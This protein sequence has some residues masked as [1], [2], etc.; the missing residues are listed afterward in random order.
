M[1]HLGSGDGPPTARVMIVGEMWGHSEQRDGRP[2]AGG[3]GEELNRMLHEAGLLRSECFVTNVVNAMP[4][5]GLI[6]SWIPKKKKEITSKMVSIRGKMCDPIIRQGIDAL[7]DEIKLVKPNLIIAAGNTALWALTGMEGILKWRG[8][9]LM[10]DGELQP[11]GH[12]RRKVIPIIH[13]A[14][15]FRDWSLRRIIIQDLRRAAKEVATEEYSNVPQWN[16]ITRPTLNEAVQKLDWLYWH[17]TRASSPVWVDF[18]LET[19]V[20]HIESAALSWSLTEAICLPFMTRE[21]RRGYWPTEEVEAAVVWRIYRVLRHANVRV[22]GQNLLYDSQYTYRHWHFVPRVAQDTMLAQHSLFCGLRKS[23]DFQASMYCDHYVYWKDDGKIA[24][25]S[26]PEDKRWRY[27]CEDCVRTREV[28]EVETALLKQ[29]GLEAV[30]AFQQKMFWPVLQCMQRGVKIDKKLRSDLAWKLQEEIDV[31]QAFFARV[32]GHPLNPRSSPQMAKL[33]YEDLKQKPI[34]KQRGKGVPSTLTWDDHALAKIGNEDPILRPLIQKIQEIRSLGV[35]LS[36][37]V[38]APLDIDGRMRTS[39]N[40][41]G[42]ETFR[43]SASENAFGTGTNLQ[44]IPKGG[45]DDEGFNLPN[46]RDIF[47]PDDGYEMFDTD[48]SKADL[49]IVTWESNCVEMKA[50][51]KEGKDP[52]VETAREFYKDPSIKKTRDDGS[53]HPK[54]RIFKS[55]AHGTHYLGTPHGLAQRLGLTVHD[56]ERTQR[57]YLGKYLAIKTWQE[58]FKKEVAAKRYVENIFGYRRYYFDRPDDAMMREAIAWLPQSTVALYINRIWM[59]LYENHP[60]IWVLLQVHDSLVGQYPIHRRDESL[61]A[62]E[63]SAQIVLPY[64]DP[65][66]IPVGVKTSSKSWGACA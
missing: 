10:M 63:K 3:S 60:A 50:M 65:L 25:A 27:N 58:E 21:D 53:E 40:V 14:M 5:A 45:D 35:F 17:I 52:Y 49:R 39:Y 6:E 8:S 36:T 57:W 4:P 44:N 66:I 7:R 1:I 28:G 47:I 43:F 29:M 61:A 13:P 23:L 16:F 20:G 24:D 37:F 12:P 55:F 26:V 41:A 19:K 59:N 46:I 64:D 30:D 9:Q 18:D 11:L 15:V 2:F 51:L 54:Y 48:L 32:L 56:A 42:T 22:R 31:R 34:W 62:I 33:F 38:L